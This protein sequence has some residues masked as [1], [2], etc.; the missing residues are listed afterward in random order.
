MRIALTRLPICV[1]FTAGLLLWDGGAGAG[2]PVPNPAFEEGEEGPEGWTLSG[3][4]GAWLDEGASGARSV[5]VTGTGKTGDTNYWR[6]K[7][8]PL[9]AFSLYELRFQ[10][11][12][13][14][15]A[16]GNPISGPVFCNRDLNELSEE[17][18]GYRSIF[19]TPSDLSPGSSWLRFGQWEAPGTIAYDDVQLFRVQPIY[20][21]R[22]DLT[23]GAGERVIGTQYQFLAPLNGLSRNHARPLERLTCYFN[24]GR[25]VF[26]GGNEVVY[27]H[28]AGDIAQHAATIE[29]NIGH[30]TRGE[31]SAEVSTDGEH[32]IELGR[33][34]SVGVHR[35]EVPG[36]CFPAQAVRVRFRSLSGGSLGTDSDFGA[37]QIYNYQYDGTLAHAPGDLEGT[38]SFA[39][40]LEED[41]RLKV[42]LEDLGDAIPGGGKMLRGTAVNLSQGAVAL[43]PALRILPEEGDATMVT[44]LGQ[45]LA[46]GETWPFWIPYSLINAG[47]TKLVFTM[48][49]SAAFRAEVEFD[50]HPLHDIRYGE[51]L[52]ASTNRV[53]LWR[54]SSGWKVSQSRPLPEASAP[55]LQIATARNEAEAAQLVVRPTAP[56]RRFTAKCG[57]LTGPR[58]ATIPEEHIEVLRVRYVP[59]S[60]PT[61]D[62]S[63]AG[64]WPDPLPPFQGPIDLE[65]DQNQPLWVRVKPPKGIPGGVYT[66]AIQL[67]AEDYHAEVPIEVEVFDFDL[68]DRMRCETAFGFD[69]GLA[70][71]YHGISDPEQRRRV[72]DQYLTLLSDHHISPYNPAALD[73]FRVTWPALPDWQGGLRDTSEKYRGQSSLRLEDDSET[74]HVSAGPQQ[75][76]AIPEGGLQISFW[77]KTGAPGQLFQ[78]TLLHY[79]ADKHWLRG[80]NNDIRM[81][82]NGEWTHFET[83][84]DRFPEGAA[85]FRLR[86]WPAPFTET[87]DTTGTAWFDDLVITDAR[88]KQVLFENDFEPIDPAALTP[89]IDWSAWDLAMEKAF[90]H[91]H[92]NSVSIPIVGM[93]GGTFHSRTEPS[94]LGYAEDTPE[95]Q[96]AFSAY[97]RA[98]EAHL[99]EKGWVDDS[100]VYW[101]DEPDPKDYEF[102]MNGFRKLKE[103]AP[104]IRRMLTEQIE[105]ELI[106]GPNL[107]CPLTPHYDPVLAEERR[108]EGDQFWWYICTGPKAPYV[109]LFID[110]PGTEL[111][112]W[113]WQTWERRID[114]LLIWQTNYW[115]SD[116]AYPPPGPPQNPYE[117]PMGWVSGYSTPHGTKMAWGNG[118]GRF[119]YPPEAAADGQPDAPVLD[120]PVGS[121]RLDMLR[122][123]IEDY[124]YLFM[125]DA[126]LKERGDALPEAKRAEYAALV[127]PPKSV[128]VN[129]TQ[130]TTDPAPIEAHRRA[131]GRAIEDLLRSH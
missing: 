35:F 36:D 61:D 107:W 85:S 90:N 88:T 49:E 120:P 83:L 121:I 32:W 65:A 7:T 57:L 39:S 50:I 3:G 114:G 55:A 1:L 96:A 31:L 97:C 131:V 124:E 73:P 89:E 38:T 108:A 112:V 28:A 71:Q 119:M 11:R 128:T 51:I 102:V 69:P 81:Q 101:F 40:I 104:R 67:E 52:P 19:I 84:V 75:P 23:L 54:A 92:F 105:P 72:Y 24:T 117:D 12:R 116:P 37:A 6:S 58:G 98:V 34:G 20:R 82:G 9:E 2:L 14:D 100:Y 80:R 64:P 127:E 43:E 21:T 95:Y 47:K 53:G 10:A 33:M 45:S 79:D 48:G 30:Y 4:A 78:V 129:L 86:L 27:R 66:G 118:D 115:T 130:F 99:I 70:F 18:R 68:P 122:D 125:L 25:L 13:L 110:H 46:A 41:P 87:G 22:G 76:V 29:V 16:G 62:S 63:I 74:D 126:L 44:G 8:L 109:T 5:A 103:H 26:G 15:G 111:R 113:G 94:L 91:Y 56:L 106:G 42:V 60:I 17:W 123:G 93:G 77:C 59:V